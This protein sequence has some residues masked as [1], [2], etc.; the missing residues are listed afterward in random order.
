M[1]YK[2]K[3]KVFLTAVL[4]LSGIA[5]YTQSLGDLGREEQKRR[6]SIPGSTVITY[7]NAPPAEPEKP[8]E[9]FAI[10]DEDFSAETEETQNNDVEEDA[11]EKYDEK[12]NPPD[13]EA[14]S[15]ETNDLYGK[16]ESYWRS[17]MAGARNKLK[18]LEDEQKELT[19]RRNALQFRHNRTNGSMRG[20]IKGEI[21]ETRQ[22][23]DLNKKNLD[24]ARE[25][26][27]SLQNT[28]RLSGAPPGWIE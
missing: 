13:K 7:E 25:E 14:D 18:Q 16:T 24:Q 27:R 15:N 2:M 28:A 10:D 3:Y 17:T 6:D 26:I 20:P 21:D 23:Q 9:E 12:S 11:G 19:S 1:K 22:A 5:A 8:D 4:C